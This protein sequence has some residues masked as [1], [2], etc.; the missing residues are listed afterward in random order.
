[1][2]QAA[3]EDKLS[4]ILALGDDHA[5]LFPGERQQHFVRRAGGGTVPGG[6]DIVPEVCQRRE[7]RTR[8]GAYIE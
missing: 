5:A 6:Q 7:E 4:E 1:M 8:R 3:R 2:R